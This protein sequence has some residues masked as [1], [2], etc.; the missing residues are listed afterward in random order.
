MVM[1]Q[2][3]T[4]ASM[5]ATLRGDPAKAFDTLAPFFAQKET[6]NAI[7]SVLRRH[8]GK[9]DLRFYRAA[10]KWFPGDPQAPSFESL[11]TARFTAPAVRA[12]LIEV[13]EQLAAAKGEP[14]SGYFYMMIRS[15]PVPGSAPGLL[16]IVKRAARYGDWRFQAPLDAIDKLGDATALPGL[17]EL[18]DTLKGKTRTGV[19]AVIAALEARHPEAKAAGKKGATKVLDPAS[20]AG[21]LVAAGLSSERALAIAALARARIDLTPR[22]VKSPVLGTTRFGGEPDLAPGM[23]W[24]HVT[25]TAKAL[26]DQ[27]L[28]GS[29][30]PPNKKGKYDVPLAFVAQ[31][32]LAELTSHDE[33]G[34]LPKTG[35]LWFFVRPDVTVGEKRQLSRHAATVLYSAKPGKLT[36]TAPPPELPK[37]FRFAAA[38]VT[39]S[40]QTPLPPP[41]VEPMDGLAML[42]S[43]EKIYR[44]LVEEGGDEGDSHACLGWARAAFYEGIPAAREQ[45][46]LQ[47]CTESVS[48]FTWGDD[49]SIF[50]CIPIAALAKKDF[51]EAYCIADE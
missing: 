41:E 28:E 35:M 20:P 3:P 2:L 36:R 47:V 39:I 19:N 45:L 44:A 43:E 7:F 8:T 42:S 27:G 33:A 25:C 14:K 32:S 37:R 29:F 15:H 1:P 6:A 48:D 40:H 51:S 16:R 21:R 50:F 5:L 49:A 24:P 23:T 38:G 31:L 17:R 13:I 30:P 12:C 18:A 4:D 9:L 10:M 34:L 11:Y 46:L 26:V 22:A